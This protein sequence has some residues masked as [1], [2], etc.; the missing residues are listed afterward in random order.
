MRIAHVITRLI[1]GG[2][3]ENTLLTCEDLLRRHGD[4]VLLVTGPALG[5]EGSL[6][7]RARAG[8]V[9][10][11]VVN[12]LRR[13]I[14]PWRDLAAYRQIKQTLRDFRPDVVHTHSAKAGVLGRAAAWSLGVPAVV[15]TVHG[16]PFHPYQGRGARALFRG[17]ER[18]AARRCHALISVADAMTDLMVDAGVAPRDRFTTIY[19]GMEVEPLLTAEVHRAE[20]RASLG[21]TEDHVVVG[22]IARLF[23]LKGHEFLVRAAREVVDR[24]PNVRFLLIGDGLLTDRIRRQ[25]AREGLREH[26]HLTGLV[27][28]ERIPELIAAIDVGVH[29]SLREGLPRAAVQMLLG[30]KPVV[31]YAIDGAPE[32]VVPEET[33]LL[34][35]P[36][37]VGKLA[38]AVDRLVGD[39]SLRS[40]L[41]AEGRRRFAEQFDHRRMTIAI[42]GVYTGLLG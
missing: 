24:H 37:S 19:S 15:H 38:A 6:I 8:G 39:R 25:I 26:F 34:V 7:Q 4:Q 27:P 9:P 21:Y 30:G 10:L 41:G 11:V 2:A 5:P 20:V 32:V 18:W 1:L 31:S 23:H 36:K 22:K 29:V 33:G 13:A 40:H 17:C 42:R 12:P 16:A 14:H 35:P 3:Q 28:A